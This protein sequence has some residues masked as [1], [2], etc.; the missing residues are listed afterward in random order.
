M[1]WLSEGNFYN[2]QGT[3]IGAERL[4]K[5]EWPEYEAK[6]KV[7]EEEKKTV[8]AEFMSVGIWVTDRPCEYDRSTIH[9]KER[10]QLRN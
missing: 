7:G 6:A 8:E 4:G 9:K 1:S 5:K 10:S 3:E 2:F